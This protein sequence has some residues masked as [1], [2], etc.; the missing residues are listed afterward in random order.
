MNYTPRTCPGPGD[1]WQLS[2]KEE[3]REAEYE[4]LCEEFWEEFIP[5]TGNE[6]LIELAELGIDEDPEIEEL[7]DYFLEK[8]GWQ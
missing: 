1:L 6:R 3:K 5:S 7:F 8:N 4:R 2:P